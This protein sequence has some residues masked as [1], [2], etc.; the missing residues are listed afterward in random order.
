MSFDS[1]YAGT[2]IS[3]YIVKA[4][5]R[6]DFRIYEDY[7][8]PLYKDNRSRRQIENCE[9]DRIDQLHKKYGFPTSVQKHPEWNNLTEFEKQQIRNASILS[10]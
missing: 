3:N 9:Y 2:Y 5:Y 8:G 4:G 10:E 6:P 7:Y 1:I